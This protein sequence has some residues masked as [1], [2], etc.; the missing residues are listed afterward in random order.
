MLGCDKIHLNL[1]KGN[2]EDLFNLK[3]TTHTKA[4]RKGIIA[5]TAVSTGVNIPL[6]V[7]FEK[8]DD[9]TSSCFVKCLDGL[10]GQ[11]GTANLRNVSVHSDRGYMLP[12]LVFEYLL[13][14]GAEVVGTVRRMAQCWPFTYQQTLKESDERTLIDV[15]GSPSLFLKWFGTRSKVLF[16][17]AF[18]NGTGRVATAV[19]TFH[20]GFEWEGVVMKDTEAKLYSNNEYALIPQFF[21]KVEG[22]TLKE[23]SETSDKDDP[24]EA[25]MKDLIKEKIDPF[26]LR[27]GK[28]IQIIIK[29]S[30]QSN[31]LYFYSSSGT[32]DWHYLRKFS[33]TSSQA[34]GAFVKAF[35]AFK[36]NASW[37]SV[38]KYLYGETWRVTLGAP[39]SAEESS[40]I[41]DSDTIVKYLQDFTCDDDDDDDKKDGHSFLLSFVCPPSNTTSND[42]DTQAS[43]DSSSEDDEYFDECYWSSRAQREEDIGAY[44]SQINHYLILFLN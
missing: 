14:Y 31:L 33:L 10:F 16:A 34:H 37:I 41:K 12:N 21:C 24:V 35:P 23:A 43:A 8:T 2:S 15:R 30:K 5:H 20:R 39:A 29:K 9:S 6:Q 27:Q 4:N 25:V 44:T 42:E 22:I 1:S 18:R 26:T 7:S 36:N 28:C 19:S 40:A 13:A 3:Y 38:A 17:S 11:S 32:A